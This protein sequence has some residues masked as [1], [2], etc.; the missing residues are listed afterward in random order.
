MAE[1]FF[2]M[3]RLLRGHGLTL[4]LEDFFLI[5]IPYDTSLKLHISGIIFFFHLRSHFLVNNGGIDVRLGHLVVCQV[6]KVSILFLPVPLFGQ[7]FAIQVVC[8]ILEFFSLSI[9]F[10]KVLSKLAVCINDNRLAKVHLVVVWSQPC[11]NCLS[12]RSFHSSCL[13]WRQTLDHLRPNHELKFLNFSLLSSWQASVPL[14]SLLVLVWSSWIVDITRAIDRLTNLLLCHHCVMLAKTCTFSLVFNF[15][16]H[17]VF[18]SSSFVVVM[19]L[20]SFGRPFFL[21]SDDLIV[22]YIFCE[23]L[24]MLLWLHVCSDHWRLLSWG[25]ATYVGSWSKTLL[26]RPRIIVRV[27]GSRKSF[28]S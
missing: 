2:N 14:Y 1:P 24:H 12:T 4:L 25:N 15:N 7:S 11:W 9:L 3:H 26:L 22:E 10:K 8:L 16:F 21:T 13:L 27:F 19:S 28:D 5:L 6:A 18:P 20:R 23:V 17:V